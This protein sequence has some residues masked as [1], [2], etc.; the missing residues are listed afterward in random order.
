MLALLLSLTPVAPTQDELRL[1]DLTDLSRWQEHLALSPEDRRFDSLD[2]STTFVDGL[3]RA[4][5][6]DQPLL[7]WAMN[8]HPL[9]CT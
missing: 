4:E 5:A 1:P 2:W 7:L 6:E 9:G 8:G 3:R